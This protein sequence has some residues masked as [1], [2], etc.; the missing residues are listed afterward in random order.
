[1]VFTWP[2]GGAKG[3]LF[4]YN[5][6]RESGEFC[7]PDLRKMLRA[8]SQSQGVQKIHII[9]HSR[10]TDVVAS[11][12]Q[13]L[14]IEAYASRSVAKRKFKIS[15]VIM[16]APDMDIDVAYSRARVLV[17]DP[18]LTWGGE[19]NYHAP[20]DG[21]GMQL[22]IYTS[23]DDL[24][25]GT[26]Q[27]LFGSDARLGRVTAEDKG[28]VETLTDRAAGMAEFISVRNNGELIGH[29]YF[30]SDPAVRRDIVAVIRDHAKAGTGG[31]SLIPLKNGFWALSE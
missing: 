9:A 16:A 11:T 15:T 23:G 13:Q 30:L 18:D 31:R 2:A 20:F 12:L 1:M 22:T 27:E 7:V 4:G 26:S 17:S 14:S 10:G 29:S 28:S 21:D 8:I 25:L 24:A 19:A 3:A 6:D 5:F